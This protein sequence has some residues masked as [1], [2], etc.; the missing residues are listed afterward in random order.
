MK[1]GGAGRRGTIC[2]GRGTCL[3]VSK[4]E[5]GLGLSGVGGRWGAADYESCACI[6]SK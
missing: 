2:R 5:C 6:P 4:H 1:G 3:P